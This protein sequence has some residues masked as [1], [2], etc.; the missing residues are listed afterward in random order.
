MRGKYLYR[1]F[2]YLLTLIVTK[3]AKL[4]WHYLRRY[5]KSSKMGIFIF[6]KDMF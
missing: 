4:L 3:E 6:Y 5:L 2:R 1:S